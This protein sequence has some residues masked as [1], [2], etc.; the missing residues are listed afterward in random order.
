MFRLSVA[1]RL[2]CMNN[3]QIREGK[4]HNGKSSLFSEEQGIDVGHAKTT[5]S[6]W[7]QKI[8]IFSS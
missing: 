5:M 2:F 4:V 1:D 7:A 6:I 3:H 8:G